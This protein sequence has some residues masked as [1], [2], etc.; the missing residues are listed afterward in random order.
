MYGTSV[1]SPEAF[2]RR[3]PVDRLEAE[4]AQLAIKCAKEQTDQAILDRLYRRLRNEKQGQSPAVSLFTMV[5]SPSNMTPEERRVWQ[6]QRRQALVPRMACSYLKAVESRMETVR[7]QPQTI[8]T[9]PREGTSNTPWKA[10]GVGVVVV[11]GLSL[12]FRDR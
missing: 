7:S 12:L 3:L 4:R 11:V 9:V 1:I 8:S 6:D 2:A 5:Q 10:I